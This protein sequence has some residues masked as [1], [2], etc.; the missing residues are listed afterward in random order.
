M[1]GEQ[2][3]LVSDLTYTGIIGNRFHCFVDYGEIQLQSF[4]EFIPHRCEFDEKI[5][6]FG[7]SDFGC[8]LENL[9]FCFTFFLRKYL[10][11]GLMTTVISHNI[12]ECIT[13]RVYLDSL[14]II[15]KNY[16]IYEICLW[17]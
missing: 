10:K 13:E 15:Y 12:C 5:L 9:T 6:I 8:E 16:A 2:P 11:R 7:L 1:S 14:Q 4:W 3:W 17:L